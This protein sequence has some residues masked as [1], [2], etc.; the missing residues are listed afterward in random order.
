MSAATCTLADAFYRASAARDID[1][2]TRLLADDVD[3]MVQGPVD[4]FPFLGRRTGR[5]AVL[6]GYKAM[7]Q[8]MS[9]IGYEVETL[10]VE[11]DRSAALI[12]ITSR[13]HESGRILSCRTSQFLRYRDGKICEMRGIIDTFDMVEQTIGRQ[14]DVPLA[15][16]AP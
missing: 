5:D 1:T 2:I 7:A 12:R 13:M 11:G 10:L 9:V 6:A 16:A 14:L 3:W 15:P 8:V 4:L